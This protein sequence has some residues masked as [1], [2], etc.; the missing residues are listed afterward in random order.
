MRQPT[1]FLIDGVDRLGKSTLIHNILNELGYHLVVHFDKPQLLLAYRPAFHDLSKSK[2]D[3]LRDYQ[4]ECNDNMFKIVHG[5]SKCIFDRTHLGEPVY[6]KRY[7]NYDGN[8][9]FDIEKSYDTSESRL[10]LLTTSDFSFQEDDGESH[11]WSQ[12][13][14]E[15]Q[16]F[17]KA[18]C[19]SSIKDK[20]IIDVHNGSGG[21]KKPN[22]ILAEA[23]KCSV[24]D[25][26]YV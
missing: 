5:G 7:R 22:E 13:V 19:K 24:Q 1:K 23:L 20:I 8:Y 15:Q 21:F 18:F 14:Q 3:S 16:D 6:A 12:R 25:L 4:F 10:V 17:I 26:V 11:D 2:N 9:V